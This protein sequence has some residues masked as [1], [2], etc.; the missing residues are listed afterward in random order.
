MT[1][2]FGLNGSQ[3]TYSEYHCG[4]RLAPG[5]LSGVTVWAARAGNPRLREKPAIVLQKLIF[6]QLEKGLRICSPM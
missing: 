5:S 2:E 6:F 1:I 3:K 4:A